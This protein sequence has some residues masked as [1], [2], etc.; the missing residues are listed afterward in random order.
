[1]QSKVA[2]ERAEGPPQELKVRSTVPCAAVKA[3][4]ASVNNEAS[5]ACGHVTGLMLEH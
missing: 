1:M 4:F 2:P 3:C 5:E